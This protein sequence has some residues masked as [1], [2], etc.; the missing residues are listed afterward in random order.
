MAFPVQ[1]L[2]SEQLCFDEKEAKTILTEIQNSKIKDEQ[3]KTCNEINTNLKELNTNNEKI[4]TGLGNDKEILKGI[5]EEYKEKYIKSTEK[6]I[7]EKET[8][9]SKLVWFGIGVVATS[10]ITVALTV[11]MK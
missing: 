9:P 7:E 5:S 3:L 6:W 2:A 4:I 1:S 8:K 10:I 11:L